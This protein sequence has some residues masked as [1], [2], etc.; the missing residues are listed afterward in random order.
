MW[1]L[2]YLEAPDQI[3][4]ASSE[5]VIPGALPSAQRGRHA[6]SAIESNGL[7]LIEGLPTDLRFTWFGP[8]A[9]SRYSRARLRPDHASRADP[10]NRILSAAEAPPFV[11]NTPNA[12][13]RDRLCREYFAIPAIIRLRPASCVAPR[14]KKGTAGV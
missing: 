6:L 10:Q 14:M 8:H 9:Q 3:S 5:G 13:P 1:N 7:P 12:G 2:N 4:C 11:G